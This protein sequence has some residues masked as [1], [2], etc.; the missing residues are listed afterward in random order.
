MD[1]AIAE[2]RKALEIQ[3]DYAHAHYRLGI[4]LKDKGQLDEAIAEFRKALQIQ[5]D[6]AAAHNNLG[7]ALQDKGQLD[8]AIAEYRKAVQIQPDDAD[9]HDNLGVVLQDKGQLDE[10]IAEFRKA[11]QIRPDAPTPTTTS[12]SPSGTRASWTRRSRS[13]GK[14]VQVQP[15]LARAHINLGDALS[16]KRQLDEAIRSSAR[17]SR[18][19]PTPPAPMT[20]SASP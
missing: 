7:F 8:E 4:A 6:D 19:S 11:L 13:T 20:A 16:D 2:Y 9:A 14:A 1:E 12:A 3:P 18:S 5:P 15:D 17:P 10:A